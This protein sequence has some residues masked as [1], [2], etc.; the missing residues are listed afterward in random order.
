MTSLAGEPVTISVVVLRAV[1]VE[2]PSRTQR[3]IFW[4]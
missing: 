3:A 4:N 2:E 1:S